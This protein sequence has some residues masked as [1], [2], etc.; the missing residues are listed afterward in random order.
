ML[1]SHYESHHPEV[2]FGR[3]D[4]VLRVDRSPRWLLPAVLAALV[5]AVIVGAL[6]NL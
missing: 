3:A 5:L 4:R 1:T 6:I 2:R